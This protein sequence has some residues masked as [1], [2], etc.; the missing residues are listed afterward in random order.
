M[1]KGVPTLRFFLKRDIIFIIGVMSVSLKEG[2]ICKKKLKILNWNR[3]QFGLFQIEEVG[4]HILEVIEE[5][6]RLIFRETLY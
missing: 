5:I 1:N 4:R 2:L 3:R 6:G